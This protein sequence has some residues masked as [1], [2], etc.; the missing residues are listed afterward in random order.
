VTATFTLRAAA[1]VAVTVRDAAGRTLRTLASGTRAAGTATVTWDGRIGAGAKTSVAP[2]GSYVVAVA[3]TTARGTYT[4]P[5]AVAVSVR[6]VAVSSLKATPV[7]PISD[8]YRDA[9]AVTF[10]QAG[11][12]T[13]SLYVYGATSATALRVIPI[14]R[15]PAGVV[16]AAWDGRDAAGRTV[17]AGTYRVRIRTVDAGLVARWSSFTPVV[18]SAKRLVAKTFTLT[19]RGDQHAPQTFVS[20]QDGAAVRASSVIPGGVHLEANGPDDRATAF[21]EVTLPGHVG[22]TSAVLRV[23]AV[24]D[25]RGESL[26]GTW[27]GTTVDGIGFIQA[28]SGTTSLTFPAATI[29]RWGPKIALA[30]N[31]DGPGT[32]DVGSL[33]LVMGYTILQ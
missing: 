28:A 7:Y 32:I 1:T 22:L 11:P 8:G 25:G 2:D 27:N 21:W 10:R 12:A 3:A 23:T 13:S 26:V 20:S 31:Q 19:L 6:G 15:K 16:S 33:T 14:G 5:L 30:V 18:V 9:S 24:R 29:A 17:R 4:I